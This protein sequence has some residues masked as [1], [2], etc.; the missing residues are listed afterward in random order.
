[1]VS[2]TPRGARRRSRCPRSEQAPHG[3]TRAHTA[4]RARAARRLLI[5]YRQG[6]EPEDLN[7]VVLD[8][9]YKLI[10]PVAEGA[11]GVVYRA[12]RVKL[13]RIVAVKV[14]HDSL[15]DELSSRERFEVEA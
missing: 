9:R 12:E 4:W 10:A 3:H 8:G 7:G 11:M 5:S 1:M 13:G 15:P 6:V 14:L 2:A